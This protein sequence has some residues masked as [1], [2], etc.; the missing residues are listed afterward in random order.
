MGGTRPGILAVVLAG[1][2]A[3]RMGGGDK[4]LLPLGGQPMLSVL[5]E[6]LRPQAAAFAISANGD[7]S[8]FA[9][10]APGVP[11]LADP[12]PGFPGPLAGVLAGM[13]HAASLGLDMVLTVPGDTPLV[14]MDLAARL[15]A[16]ASPIACAASAGRMHP[17]VALWP[18]GLRDDLRAA[19]A[20][21]EGKVSR[22][23]ARHGCMPVEWP[24]DP[25]L[26][27]NAPEDLA[28]LEAAMARGA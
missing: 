19:M 9:A 28:A 3:R 27:A 5:M 12:L 11:V 25:F 20:T 13:D 4:T 24:G 2:L 21:G 17:P 14:P 7:P 26:N 16:A 8:R 6:R 10:V 1:G 22:W 23:A 18:A 15:H